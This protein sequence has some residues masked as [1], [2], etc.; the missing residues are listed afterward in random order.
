MAPDGVLIKSCTGEPKLHL[1]SV[2]AEGGHEFNVTCFM[3]STVGLLLEF[4]PRP[5]NH[6]S[7]LLLSATRT[8]AVTISATSHKDKC[9]SP[10]ADRRP[11]ALQRRERMNMSGWDAG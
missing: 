5:T 8:V 3:F 9:V 7:P 11:G 2:V 6:H 4:E 1:K 10:S